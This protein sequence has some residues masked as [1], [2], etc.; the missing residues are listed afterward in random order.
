MDEK[1]INPLVLF[2]LL[3]NVSQQGE[4]SGLFYRGYFFSAILI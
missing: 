3:I 1:A 4:M 2:L